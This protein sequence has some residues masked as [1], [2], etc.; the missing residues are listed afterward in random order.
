[1]DE[2]VNAWR[3]HYMPHT[4]HHFEHIYEY[5]QANNLAYFSPTRMV[6]RLKHL[7]RFAGFV[8]DLKSIYENVAEKR[9]GY[10]NEPSQQVFA[11]FLSK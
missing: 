4:R 2:G 7:E 9:Q 6:S 3:T 1:M 11:P 5:D 10:V 8:P